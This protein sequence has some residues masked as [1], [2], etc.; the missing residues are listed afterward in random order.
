MLLCPCLSDDKKYTVYI[1]P[2]NLALFETP[3]TAVSSALHPLLLEEFLML[4]IILGNNRKASPTDRV[5]HGSFVYVR[6]CL[7]M[8]NR[9]MHSHASANKFTLNL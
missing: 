3:L 8:C 9:V 1:F 7:P 6:T 4:E 2:R 5:N